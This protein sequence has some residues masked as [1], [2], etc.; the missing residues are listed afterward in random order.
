MTVCAGQF[1]ETFRPFL[2]PVLS[3]EKKEGYLDGY[4]YFPFHYSASHLCA[5]LLVRVR[6]APSLGGLAKPINVVARKRHKIFIGHRHAA[7]LLPYP[8]RSRVLG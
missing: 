4:A 8:F 6:G 5:N 2:P 7:P 1:H 3:W